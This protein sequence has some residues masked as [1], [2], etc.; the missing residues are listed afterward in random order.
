VLFD[1]NGGS[2][3]PSQTVNHGDKI[4][5]PVD[6][7]KT[8]YIF[9]GWYKDSGLTIPWNFSKDVVTSNITLYAKWNPVSQV[10]IFVKDNYGT[11][12]S[13]AEVVLDGVGTKYSD[14]NGKVVFN[15]VPYG[16]YIL[17]VYVNNYGIYEVSITVN[18]SNTT[19]TTSL[20][21][22]YL[23]LKVK[24]LAPNGSPISGAYVYLKDNFYAEEFASGYTNSQGYVTF[25][26]LV[27]QHVV[28]GVSANGYN[29]GGEVDL[30]DRDIEFIIRMPEY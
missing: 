8:G 5:K 12:I 13:N 2:F 3:V 24:V 11:I 23:T 18:S 6:P 9:A 27:R 21:K 25:N 22:V 20:V 19:F 15:N 16:T 28:I 29:Y 30:T 26:G 14:S 1:T 7:T 17:G 10:T 4:T